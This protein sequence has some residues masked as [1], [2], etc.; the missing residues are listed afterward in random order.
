VKTSLPNALTWGINENG[1]HKALNCPVSCS[2]LDISEISASDIIS[3]D[4]IYD[5]TVISR[6]GIHDEKLDGETA[7]QSG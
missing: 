7:V 5:A 4:I 3:E 6:R 2:G 1:R